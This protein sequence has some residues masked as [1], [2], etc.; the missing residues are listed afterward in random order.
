MTRTISFEPYF[1]GTQ[2]IIVLL[3]KGFYRHPRVI[4]ISFIQHAFYNVATIENNEKTSMCTYVHSLIS[5]Y[6]TF[7]CV[8][9]VET[10]D[11]F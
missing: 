10:R 5:A 3:V 9:R 1:M 6:L 11:Y 4:V 8:K 2:I 7:S